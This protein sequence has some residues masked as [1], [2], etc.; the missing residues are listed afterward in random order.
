MASF[1]RPECCS[2]QLPQQQRGQGRLRAVGRERAEVEV[3]VDTVAVG[4][5]FGWVMKQGL[6]ALVTA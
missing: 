5:L 3:V 2:H 6:V 4:G 1:N